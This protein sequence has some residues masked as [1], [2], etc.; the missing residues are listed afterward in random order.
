[1]GESAIDSILVKACESVCTLLKFKFLGSRSRSHK[2]ANGF[3]NFEKYFI[4]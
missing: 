1:M 4:R 2:S 3:K